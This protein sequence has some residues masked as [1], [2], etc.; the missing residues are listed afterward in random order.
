M[1]MSVSLQKL[2]ALRRE[3]GSASPP[4]RPS[5]AVTGT[6]SRPND[7]APHDPR[8][9]AEQPGPAAQSIDSLRR[10]LGVRARTVVPLPE[11]GP[12]DRSL[13]GEEIAPGVRLVETHL[14]MPAPPT[15]WSL[16]FRSE[17][18]TSELQSLMRISYAVLCLQK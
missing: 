13:P 18:H 15:A 2:R 3:V 4:S 8:R 11:R 5:P 17:E 1:A 6:E 7:H 14:P 12:V 10:L 9:H 16:A